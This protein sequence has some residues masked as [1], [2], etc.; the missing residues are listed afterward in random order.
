MLTCTEAVVKEDELTPSILVHK[1]PIDGIKEITLKVIKKTK[2]LEFELNVDK[3]KQRKALEEC[4]V[5]IPKKENPNIEFE[6]YG[7][8]RE[9]LAM[10]KRN[11]ILL[12]G[13]PLTVVDNVSPK[14]L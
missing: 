10:L 2:N 1:I 11:H 4:K 13:N 8:A 7:I 14:D 5:K 6:N 3:E 9:L 12:T